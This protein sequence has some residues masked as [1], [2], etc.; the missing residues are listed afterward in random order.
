MATA[1]QRL[2]FLVVVLAGGCGGD[3]PGAR[4]VITLGPGVDASAFQT[5]ALRAFP[6]PSRAFDP[7]APIP[8]SGVAQ[9]ASLLTS[10]DFPREYTLGAGTG[11]TNVAHWLFVAWLSHRDPSATTTIESGDVYCTVPFE[12]DDCGRTSNFCALTSHVDCVL[13][14]VAP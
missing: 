7:A 10:S 5:L 4:G 1:I 8:G 11:T 3:G 6:N 12:S 2:S 9:N 14:T 13:A